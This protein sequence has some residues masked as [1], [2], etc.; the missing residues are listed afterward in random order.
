MTLKCVLKLYNF[1]F[2]FPSV[3][4][5]KTITSLLFISLSFQTPIKGMYRSDE[6]GREF[7]SDHV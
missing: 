4:T 1:F 2:H 5:L 7:A 3:Y 6:Y